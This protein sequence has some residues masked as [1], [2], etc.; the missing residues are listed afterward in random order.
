MLAASVLSI[1]ARDRDKKTVAIK[2][3]LPITSALRMDGEKVQVTSSETSASF[4]HGL[5][6]FF[7]EGR[8]LANINHKNIVRVLNFFRA[9][10][11]RRFKFESALAYN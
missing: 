8:T 9:N 1:I 10:E 11:T 3:Y 2:E 5:K 4:G 7:E 6:Y